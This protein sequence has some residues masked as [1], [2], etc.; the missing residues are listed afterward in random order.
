M[1][2][3]IPYIITYLATVQSLTIIWRNHLRFYWARW[4]TR[5]NQR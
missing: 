2:V 4:K 1:F 5:V 3:E